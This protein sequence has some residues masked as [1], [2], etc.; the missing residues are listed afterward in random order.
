MKK[1]GVPAEIC[2]KGASGGFFDSR[3][4]IYQHA[5]LKKVKIDAVYYRGV[6]Q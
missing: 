4:H 1:E 3:G 6:L 2:G 5:V